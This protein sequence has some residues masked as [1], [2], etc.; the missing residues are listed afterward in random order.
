MVVLMGGSG[1]TG[2]SLL[3]NILNRHTSIFAGEESNLFCKK[4]LY[5][6]FNNSKNRITKRGLFG[7][8]NHGWH[9][10]NGIDLANNNYDITNEQ[11]N[12][13]AKNTE[14]FPIFINTLKN[15]FLQSNEHIWLEK[16]PANT[17]AFRFFLS[18]FSDGRVI[19]ITRNPLDTIASLMGRGYS[20]V[21]AIGIYLI[22]TSAGLSHLSNPRC[23]TVKYENLV[24]NQTDTI[25]S[26]CDFLNIDFEGEMLISQNEKIAVSKLSGWQYD[27]TANIGAKSVGR[28]YKLL[29][30]QQDE[31]LNGISGLCINN[32]GQEL[33][34]LQHLDIKAIAKALSYELDNSTIN[35]SSNLKSEI[36]KD[37]LNRLFRR[38]PTGFKYP[39]SLV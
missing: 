5:D 7:L 31:I 2:S 39:L 4:E 17:T 14:S 24:T 6:N 9:I 18:H 37:R 21:Y 3:K 22:N 23:L 10:Y 16:T 32:V 33:F 34:K 26:I 35:K 20:L 12:D 28:F 38:Y 36:V 13:F 29:Q 11:L 15:H 1:S 30:Q 19:H 8:K 25:N 27:E